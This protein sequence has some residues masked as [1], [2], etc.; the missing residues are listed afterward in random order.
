MPRARCMRP[1]AVWPRRTVPAATS[2]LASWDAASVPAGRWLAHLD[3][4]CRCL[5]WGGLTHQ[6]LAVYIASA[7][8]VRPC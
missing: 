5:D 1:G 4:A 8:P 6:R 2:M 3:G 7:L